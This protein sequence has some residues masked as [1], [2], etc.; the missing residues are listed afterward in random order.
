MMNLM[1]IIPLLDQVPFNHNISIFTKSVLSESKDFTIWRSPV[2]NRKSI[3]QE[4]DQQEGQNFSCLFWWQ[5]PELNL[6]IQELS[7]WDWFAPP[8]F[9]R[10]SIYTP[11]FR[12]SLVQPVRCT[13][14][15][16]IPLQLR[17]KRERQP[18]FKPM[19]LICLVFSGENSRE[20]QLQ[21]HRDP[22]CWGRQCSALLTWH[23]LGTREPCPKFRRASPEG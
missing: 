4:K 7:K 13:A 8:S 14:S 12:S 2:W 16:L 23:Y 20:M 3:L 1:R 19:S 18:S 21:T 10:T 17:P 11:I 22:G 6:V 15:S 9:W 5:R